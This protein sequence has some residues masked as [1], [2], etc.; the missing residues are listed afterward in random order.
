MAQPPPI[1]TDGWQALRWDPL[2]W[3]LDDAAPGVQ[4]RTLVELFGRP[5][6]S[7][8]VR[9]SL[10]AVNAAEPVASLLADLHPDGG[11]ATAV[12]PWKRFSGP[13]W[14]LLAAVEWGA[15]PT[16]PRLG[17][18]AERM[19]D[20][21]VGDGGIV[22]ATAEGPSVPVTARVVQSMARL[23][24]WSHLRVREAV[25]WL[26]EAAPVGPCGGWSVHSGESLV[27]PVAILTAVA[28]SGENRPQLQRRAVESIARSIGV[29][30]SDR[31]G[32]PLLDR[33]DL[34]E[35]LWAL[36]RAGETYGGWMREPL[37][38]LQRLQDEAG[39]WSRTL[40]FPAGLPVGERPAV[41][42]AS[43]GVTLRAVVALL[44]WAVDA[45]LPRMYPQ[46]P[47]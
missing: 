12:P 34:A 30:P 33:T 20:E 19:L 25:A 8:A 2:G 21:V 22:L 23:G 4:W 38:R 46:K 18:G 1:C 7:P 14:R 17:A 6:E 5:E 29:D 45:E 11:W 31:L 26:D 35:T 28:E 32:V 13:W 44:R 3:L 16:D 39:R 36:A 40:P 15:D 37:L 42:V 9:R 24:R 27:V 43:R 41:G 10:G 47:E